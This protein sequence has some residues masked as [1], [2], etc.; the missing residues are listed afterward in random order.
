MRGV[1][2][3]NVSDGPTLESIDVD[4]ASRGEVVVRIAASGICGS[5][6]HA[7]HGTSGVTTL[8]SVLGHEAAGVVEEVGEGVSSVQPGDRVVIAAVGSCQVC[9]NCVNGRAMLCSSPGRVQRSRG[10]GA[11]GTSWLHTADGD[12]FAYVG[13]GSMAEL[14]LLP[15]SM[16]VKVP[17]D[18][19]LDVI[20]PVSCG[21]L[22]GLGAALNTARPDPGDAVLVI[23]CGGVGLNVIQGC[24][25]AGAAVVVAADTNRS[26]LDLA[27]DFGATHLV[28]SGVDDLEAIVRALRPE[29]V[30]VAYEVVGRSALIVQAFNL[31]RPRGTC[32][33][34][35][36]TPPTERLEIDARLFLGTERRLVGSFFGS[37]VPLR[38]IPQIVELYRRG[39]IMLDEFITGRYPLADFAQALADSEAGKGARSVLV[40]S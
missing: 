27:A 6:L 34:V 21:V 16:V 22:T 10:L 11:A 23:G 29:G 4:A 24:R 8:P 19:P 7:I 3:R 12:V 36:A 2:L 13:V 33:I 25:L 15:Q 26:R 17:D 14:A 40:M 32:V 1:V 5:D 38:D 28:E 30:D 39:R 31:L 20:A 37:S 18:V 35:G 9:P